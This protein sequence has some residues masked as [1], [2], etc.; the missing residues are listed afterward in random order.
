V[1][2]LSVAAGN[3]EWLPSAETLQALEGYTLLRTDVN[4]WIQLTT[5]GTQ[6]WVDV[7]RE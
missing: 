1:A 4:G 6:L 7:E 3:R 5:D 2:L